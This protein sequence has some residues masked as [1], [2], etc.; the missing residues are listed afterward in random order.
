MKYLSEHEP[1]HCEVGILL[2]IFHQL[3]FHHT[4]KSSRIACKHI[5]SC[6]NFFAMNRFE[7]YSNIAMQYRHH[8]NA[9]DILDSMKRIDFSKIKK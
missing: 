8:T 9:Y 3:K 2:L 5:Q 7:L 4:A 1:T 6:M